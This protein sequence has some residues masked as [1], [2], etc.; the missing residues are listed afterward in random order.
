MS[1]PTK[2]KK[3][4]MRL[5]NGIGSVH[6]IGDGKN[7]RRPWRARV[8]SHIEFDAASGTAK[9][10]YITLGYFEKEADAIAALFEYKKNPYTME[11]S[12]ATFADVFEM[13][14]VKKYP[15]ISKISQ[16][17]YN[18]AFKNSAPLHNMKM[19]DIRTAHLEK[20][21]H[22]LQGGYQL[23]S[24]LKTFWG[25]VF[26]YAM[27]HDIIQKNYSEFVKVQAKDTG[28][29]RTDIP[30]EDRAKIWTA[31]DAGD[32]DAQIVM[33][34][35]YTGMRPT[36][37]LLVKKE[38]VDLAN[39][40]MVGGIKT[41]AGQNRRIPIHRC[42]LPFVE[43]M[44]QTEGEYLLMWTGPRQKTPKNFTYHHFI[45]NVFDPLMERIG[46]SKYTPHYCRHTAAT[47]M[48]E[49][50]VPDDLRKLILGHK[51]ADITDR[52]THYSDAMILE[53]IDLLP[54]RM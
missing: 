54:D 21:M 35:L 42:I 38:D 3:R 11:A 10:K 18:G 45:K 14:K 25:L 43:R 17:G 12:V 27:E 9:Q 26:K 15:T 52:Y 34:Y 8:P 51:S 46:L 33:V 1:T 31:I 19:R 39:R 49:A 2:K 7:R 53:A 32:T 47:M 23:H 44:M 20:V 29:T 6:K 22:E 36:E 4:H 16:S 30:A 40:I 5:P 24:R 50:N 28:T 37:L 48:R 41:E 13:W